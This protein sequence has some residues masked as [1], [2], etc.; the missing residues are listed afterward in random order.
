MFAFVAMLT[1]V[2][3][4]S[5]LTATLVCK[6]NVGTTFASLTT[7]VKVFVLVKRGF[8]MSNG[9]PFVTTVVMRFVPGLWGCAGVQVMVPLALM[10]MPVGGLIKP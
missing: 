7:T 4:V 3:N 6:G 8:T 5:S 9:L 2:S 10:L 1:T